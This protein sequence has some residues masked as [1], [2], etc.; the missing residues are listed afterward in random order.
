ML[1]CHGG[2]FAC[3]KWNRKGVF[4]NAFERGWAMKVANS[5]IMLSCRQIYEARHEKTES[6]RVSIS[7]RR[8][9]VP[10]DDVVDLPVV[11][12]ELSKRTTSANPSSL[13]VPS[14]EENDQS[15]RIRLVE[16]L[17]KML[18]GKEIKIVPLSLKDMTSAEDGC[19]E[20]ARNKQA[21]ESPERREGLLWE[22]AYDSTETFSESEELLLSAEGTIE[23]TDGSTFAF[24][25][26]FSLS[27][28]FAMEQSY[29]LRAGNAP[30]YDPLVVDFQGGTIRFGDTV[31]PFDLEGDGI[32]ESLPFVSQG[33][34]F[35]ALDKNEDGRINDGRELF[36][37]T[38]GDGFSELAL[39]DNDGNGW[40]D[41][42][43]AVFR[44]LRLWVKTQTGEDVLLKL[45]DVGI[46]AISLSR[47]TA[48]FHFK[49]ENG[50]LQ[51]AMRQAGVFVRDNQSVGLIV[52]LDVVV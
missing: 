16:T 10:L 15:L 48:P 13:E 40:I 28:S 14:S 36:G 7:S 50:E 47:V 4:G 45:S 24:K 8:A 42:A 49:D 9:Q 44:R 27:R 32:L 1:V 41:E 20:E 22:V 17:V 43:D 25:L 5:N 11:S 19:C 21:A 39:H 51:G 33:S 26:S 52:Q 29:R 6:L 3:V 12:S 37:P 46:A 31:I 23:T 35:L 18:T 2:R 34:G 30:L 38:T